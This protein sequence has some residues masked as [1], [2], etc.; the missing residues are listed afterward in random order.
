M[1]QKLENLQLF[2]GLK[3]RYKVLSIPG[4]RFLE[5]IYVE[6]FDFDA[7]STAASVSHLSQGTYEAA[8]LEFEGFTCA[9]ILPSM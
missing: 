5:H 7:G 3:N 6:D 8:F 4:L 1:K 2:G 9:Y